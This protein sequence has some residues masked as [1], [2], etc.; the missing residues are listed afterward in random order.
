M[1]TRD[2]LSLQDIKL[3]D[4]F[5]NRKWTDLGGDLEASYDGVRYVDFR[6]KGSETTRLFASKGALEKALELFV[7]DP[8]QV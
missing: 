8:I 7:P 2:K 5:K 3:A 4:P 1:P 6:V